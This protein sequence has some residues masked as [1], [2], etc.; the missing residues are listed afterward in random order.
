MRETT[1][2]AYES[3]MHTQLFI[4]DV[5]IRKHQDGRS[6]DA[7]LLIKFAMQ[8]DNKVTS[9]WKYVLHFHESGVLTQNQ[10][11]NTL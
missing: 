4:P 7:S 8:L 6:L 9:C 3:E 2:R 10:S 11:K 5:L 1:K